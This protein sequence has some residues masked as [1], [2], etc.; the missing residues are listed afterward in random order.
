MRLVKRPLVRGREIV[1]DDAVPVG[2]A[3]LRYASGVD[4]VALGHIAGRHRQVPAVYDE[5]CRALGP[6][7]LPHFLAGLSLLV[8]EGAL[9]QR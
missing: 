9:E 5:Y 2:G 8:A 1:L 4:L 6:V 7:P 3:A